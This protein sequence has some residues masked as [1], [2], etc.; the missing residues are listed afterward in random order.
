MRLGS[1][2]WM[3]LKYSSAVDRL[4]THFSARFCH[5]YPTWRCFLNGWGDMKFLV[6]D[7]LRN[8][9]EIGEC[10]PRSENREINV[11]K[12]ELRFES[13]GPCCT[14]TTLYTLCLSTTVR[15]D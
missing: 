3:R 8:A 9:H 11:M 15:H 1:S 14:P 13:P 6:L 4:V 10:L 5:E 7:V 2:E 12:M